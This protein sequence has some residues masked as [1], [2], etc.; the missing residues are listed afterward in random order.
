MIDGKELN[1]DKVHSNNRYRAMEAE[2]QQLSSVSREMVI[3][4]LAWS[5][6][7]KVV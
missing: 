3:Y 2:G 5:G 4:T 1:Q 7:E 6:S